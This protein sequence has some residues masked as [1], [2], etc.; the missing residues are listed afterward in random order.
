[1]KLHKKLYKELHKS[2]INENAVKKYLSIKRTTFEENE[3]TVDQITAISLVKMLKDFKLENGMSPPI[4]KEEVIKLV[5]QINL[6]ILK[7]PGDIQ[8]LSFDGFVH[9]LL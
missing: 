2:Y 4:L 9:F 7:Q 5:K 1:M 8:T 3:K 6:L